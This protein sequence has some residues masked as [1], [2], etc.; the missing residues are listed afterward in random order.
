MALLDV[1]R[2]CRKT[3]GRDAF[4]FYVIVGREGDRLEVV[5]SLGQK[6]RVS[7]SHLEPTQHTV[8]GKD[9]K[10]ELEKLNLA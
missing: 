10:G 8:A 4:R 2:V 3:S 9:V 7:A 1:G 6:R 5:D